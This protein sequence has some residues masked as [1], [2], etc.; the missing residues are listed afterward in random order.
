MKKI[1]NAMYGLFGLFGAF[2]LA[3]CQ[4]ETLPADGVAADGEGNVMFT[5]SAPEAMETSRATLGS[6]SNSALGGLSNV[7][8]SQY[9]LRYQLAVYRVDGTGASATYTQVVAPQVKIVADGYEPVTYNLRLTP[10]REYRAVA[11]A[12]FVREGQTDDLYYD[13]SDFTDIHQ[14]DLP[15]QYVINEESKDAYFGSTD[16]TVSN[17]DVPATS[18]ELKRPFAKLRI[19]TTDWNYGGLG[20]EMPDKVEV[21]YYNCKRFLALNTLTGEATS[22]NLTETDGTVYTATLNKDEKAYALGYDKTDNNRTIV[23][24]YLMAT[25]E[26]TPIHMKFTAK[27]GETVIATQN[28]NTQIPIQRNWLTT[29]IGN[30]LTVGSQFDIT[31]NDKFTNDWTVG[32]EWWKSSGYTPKKP[33]YDEQT[34]SYLIRNKEEFM[35]V[36]DHI[37][38]ILNYHATYKKKTP[39]IDIKA[40]IDMSGVEWKPIFPDASAREYTVNG[41]GHTLRNFSMNGKFGAIYEYKVTILGTTITLGTYNAYT[42]IWGKF[43][44]IMK[45][46][47][48]ENITINGLA[49]D[50]VHYDTEGNPID[51]SKE[52]AYFAGIVGYTGGNQWSMSSKFINVHA[53]HINI[54]SSKTPAQNLG[55]LVGWVGSGGGSVGSRSISFENCS[56]EDIHLTGYQA[57]GL[58]GQILGDRGAQFI[59][60]KTEDIYIR[61][62]YISASSGFIGNIGDGGIN[63]S[64]D[65][66]IEI[67]NCTPATHV[68]YIN[69]KTGEQDDYAPQSPYYGHKND[70]DV[71]TID[72][73][74]E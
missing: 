65:A 6:N 56:T 1:G 13:T 69:D 25:D 57:G 68:E 34:C 24:D 52:Y 37:N 63:I 8:Y 23:V 36:N 43:D 10:N 62:N 16:V 47:N 15:L 70:V 19:V 17:T 45:N 12:D 32:E 72:G 66:Y 41:N 33:E 67:N 39:T 26:Q 11:W 71:V 53:K 30:A 29:I 18:F 4:N 74:K 3:G 49:N 64:F 20:E 55:G 40:D 59:D 42:G 61:Y 28:L 27:N 35:W 50:K 2:A 31:I 51:H 9:D 22:T 14:A 58:V 7:D 46:I 54:K 60:C 21:T 48:F 5:L 73:V 38:E 44:G